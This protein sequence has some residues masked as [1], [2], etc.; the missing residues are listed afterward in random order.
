MLPLLVA[1]SATHPG[2]STVQ[3]T[4]AGVAPGAP[5]LSQRASQNAGTLARRDGLH[6][7]VAPVHVGWKV[8]DG[9][10]TEAPTQFGAAALDVTVGA[11]LEAQIGEVRVVETSVLE[12]RSYYLDPVSA[13]VEREI[14]VVPGWLGVSGRLELTL[15]VFQA[16]HAKGTPNEKP[17]LL[18]CSSGSLAQAVIGVQLLNDLE[19]S[20]LAGI[21]DDPV[22]L[23]D[24]SDCL[25]GGPVWQSSR[26]LGARAELE[27]GRYW[28]MGV[29]V[30]HVDQHRHA[31]LQ[32]E[33][34]GERSA[35]EHESTHGHG[36]AQGERH[37]HDGG[38]QGVTVRAHHG[39]EGGAWLSA[40]F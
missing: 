29:A 7:A 30:G 6:V 40:S 11:W 26:W 5:G 37:G 32:S 36:E 1:L 25:G 34:G 18:L 19:L 31:V 12:A 35:H 27:L 24:G 8:A 22:H 23:D 10:P 21:G 39:V 38:Q 20:A 14:A 17:P 15:S 3:T 2:W 13:A 16:T 33:H 28:S 9:V 4:H